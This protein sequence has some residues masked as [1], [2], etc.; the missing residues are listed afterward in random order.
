[1]TWTTVSLARA[2]APTPHSRRTVRARARRTVHDAYTAIERALDDAS[3]RPPSE[4]PE[5]LERASDVVRSS[6]RDAKANGNAT[7]WNSISPTI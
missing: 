2:V 1:M 3:S 4:R 5:A 6:L 7:L